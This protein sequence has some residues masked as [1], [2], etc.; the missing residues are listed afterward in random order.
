MGRKLIG[1]KA[2]YEG[3]K[4]V[5]DL[6]MCKGRRR[7]VFACKICD[8]EFNSRVDAVQNGSTLSC[9]CYNKS[10]ERGTHKASNTDLYHVWEAMKQ[11]CLNEK[12][13]SY[14]YYG[15]KGVTIVTEW[16]KFEPFQK[17]ALENG[18]RKG[19]EL[20]KDIAK[21]MEYSPNSCKFIPKIENMQSKNQKACAAKYGYS[22]V[23]YS[24]LRGKY[25]GSKVIYGSKYR[26]PLCSTP[27]EAST[28]L[29]LMVVTSSS[30]L[31]SKQK[32]KQINKDS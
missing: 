12:H 30:S 15:G 25:F 13:P 28:K 4:V 3:T 6:G 17:W 11:R 14:K 31:G 18:Y 19:L 22:H 26:T 23:Y 2:E 1:L 7:A 5:T 16:Y 32:Q 9:G 20:D 29:Q 27:K 8:K 21:N 10:R 24:K